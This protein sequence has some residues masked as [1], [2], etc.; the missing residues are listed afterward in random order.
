MVAPVVMS[1]LDQNQRPKGYELR[2][3]HRTLLNKKVPFRALFPTLWE[4]FSCRGWT[5]T[6]DLQ[7]MS[8]NPDFASHGLKLA[9]LTGFRTYGVNEPEEL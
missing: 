4:L 7:V 8:Y 1:G 9:F 6:S 2:S 3:C 5:R